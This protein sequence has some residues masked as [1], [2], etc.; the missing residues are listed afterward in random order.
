MHCYLHPSTVRLPCQRNTTMLLLRGCSSPSLDYIPQNYAIYAIATPLFAGLRLR[1]CTQQSSS[2]ALC[3]VCNSAS[4]GHTCFRHI[5]L[6]AVSAAAA[7]KHSR[8]ISALDSVLSLIRHT[9]H[10]LSPAAVAS[11]PMLILSCDYC[12]CLL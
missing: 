1:S 10:T 12:R 3:P 4:A 5:V 11:L 8:L 7:L 6:S 9:P 2:V